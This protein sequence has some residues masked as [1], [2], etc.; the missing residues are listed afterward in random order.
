MK[1]SVQLSTN[2]NDA[3]ESDSSE[4]CI[5]CTTQARYSQLEEH[6]PKTLNNSRELVRLGLRFRL[7]KDL[8]YNEAGKQF[9]TFVNITCSA[10]ISNFYYTRKTE[11][12]RVSFLPVINRLP[13][14]LKAE[15]I[16][17]DVTG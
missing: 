12:L 4:H 10:S 14:S 3:K 13:T 16:Y 9:E 15:I 8:F 2:I 17:A 7:T 1:R 5:I 11:K 6:V